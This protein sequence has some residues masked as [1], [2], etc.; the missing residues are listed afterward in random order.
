MPNWFKKLLSILF[1]IVG[2]LLILAIGVSVIMVLA[3]LFGQGWNPFTG[4]GVYH[5]D[6]TIRSVVENKT[7]SVKVQYTIDKYTIT[8]KG[9]TDYSMLPVSQLPST[10]PTT[11]TCWIKDGTM[12]LK[13]P[14]WN[15]KVMVWVI[16]W[17]LGLVLSCIALCLL[18]MVPDKVIGSYE[19]TEPSE[20]DK[21]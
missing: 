17:S 12:Y 2:S 6:C 20:R 14:N 7:D 1:S 3:F 18:S 21:P 5:D 9:I 8:N 19:L 10:L 13:D 16:S 15:S 4:V 11:V